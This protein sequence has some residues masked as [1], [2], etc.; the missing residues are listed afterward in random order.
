MK[1]PRRLL[2]GLL[3]L[4]ALTTVNAQN[5]PSKND[6]LGTIVKTSE[7]DSIQYIERLAAY[8]F[9]QKLNSYRAAE[10]LNTL[11]WDDSL[12]LACRN[13][14]QWMNVNNQLS[15]DEKSGTT[16]YSGASPGDRYSF[17]TKDNGKAL[18]CGENAL[19]N[20]SA[21]GNN[22][23][24]IA[25]RVA[26]HSFEQWQA[27]PGHNA[28]MLAGS[29]FVEGTAFILKGDQVWATSLF[30]RKPFTSAYNIVSFVKPNTNKFVDGP[31]SPTTTANN[32]NVANNTTVPT[33]KLST[34]QMEKSIRE[35]LTNGIYLDIDSDK[36][37]AQAAK[38]HLAYMTL[39]K[40]TGVKEEKGKSRYTGK[41]TR[42]RV[43]K[44]SHGF[45]LFKRMRTTVQEMTFK[46]VYD[47]N[48][49]DPS[50]AVND[51]TADF[52]KKRSSKEELKS[53]GMDIQIRKVKT[54]FTVY[55]VVLERRM[56]AKEE[57][58]EKADG[59]TAETT[60]EE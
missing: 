54:E 26:Q 19:Y 48:T 52:D 36:S 18:W 16:A 12:W 27:S 38:S 1:T 20:Y 10:Q 15:H 45:E 40:T 41:T 5:K 59:G 14:S 9:H 31:V 13:H 46:K 3:S 50:M 49:F 29:A 23:N 42:K 37:L 60:L 34:S 57:T 22:V 51:V 53:V 47:A 25:E 8:L 11:A 4:I 24:D 39:H 30:A 35:A 32:T 44:S 55:V 58:K 6:A 28:N 7:T 2:V 33:K 17:V 21:D 56:K 43:M